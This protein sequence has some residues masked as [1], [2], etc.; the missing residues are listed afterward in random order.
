MLFGKFISRSIGLI[1]TL[2]LARL[3]TPE[4]YGIVA[5]ATLMIFLFDTISN[6]GLREYIVYK[7]DLDQSDLSSAWT[8]NLS[9]KI[10]VWILFLITIPFI[11][12]YYEKPELN[13]VLF[14]ISFILPIE[15][16]KNVGLFL[17]Q[18]ELNYKP[19]FLL[20][21][22]HKIIAFA[23]VVPVAFWLKNYWAM[24]I[25]NLVS[26]FVMAL[27]SYYLHKFRPQFRLSNI[28][29]QWNFSKWMMPKS[30]LGFS[31]AEVDTLLVSKIF[32][33][34]SLGGFNLMKSIVGM[35]GRD[36]I[37]PAT[38][39]LL[40]SF[41]KVKNDS[42]RFNFQLNISLFFMLAVSL[43]I[44]LFL[45]LFHYQIILLLLG[46]KWISYTHVFA[47]LSI[48]I[49]SQSVT[50]VLEHC[51]TS[52]G[53][54]K[55]L[56]YFEFWGVLI[57]VLT[58]LLIKFDSLYEFSVTRGFLALIISLIILIY[59]KITTKLSF[60]YLATLILPIIL[61]LLITY[62][63]VIN[64][65]IPPNIGN[66][67]LVAIYGIEFTITYCISMIVIYYFFRHKNEVVYF[68]WLLSQ[69]LNV[70][71]GIKKK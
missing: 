7:D 49:L 28:R 71:P 64:T 32:D 11:A 36:V 23:V 16:F 68:R 57:T 59:I 70:I 10:I 69:A 34:S 45:W 39:P 42:A 35:V 6:T 54:I 14:A 61:S 33:F 5:I 38:E 50:A 52:L 37:V 13:S 27:G 51:L 20:D 9:I 8:F 65:N 40:A 63:A 19:Q 53:R 29:H 41:S 3:L 24:I 18:K 31:R 25:G 26:Y 30:I 44:M 43:P 1:S 12:D 66:F 15:A 58:L 17:F 2:I 47:A 62:T 48:L 60:I 22:S 46:E 4:D 55:V 67:F 21:V 56:F